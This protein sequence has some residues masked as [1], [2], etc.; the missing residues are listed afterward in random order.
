VGGIWLVFDFE[1]N[2][3]WIAMVPNFVLPA[4]QILFVCSFPESPVWLYS[5]FRD[6]TAFQV[7]AKLRG[8]KD[9]EHEL[10]TYGRGLE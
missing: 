5:R 9:V 1:E 6:D 2:M 4:L 3:W 8:Y 10:Q 7:L